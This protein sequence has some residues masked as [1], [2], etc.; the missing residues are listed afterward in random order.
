MNYE[1]TIY[2]Y[3]DFLLISFTISKNNI[4]KEIKEMIIM[5]FL[6]IIILVILVFVF[7]NPSGRGNNMSLRGSEYS[8]NALDILD[9]R[10]ASG[11]ISEEEYVKRRSILKDK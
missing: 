5:M 10:F 11:E 3:I 4:D 1:K 8:N 7:L 6:P 2:K 9:K